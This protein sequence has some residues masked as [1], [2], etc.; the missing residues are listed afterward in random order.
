MKRAVS[1]KG[2][3]LRDK[4]AQIVAD[5]CGN[6]AEWNGEDLTVTQIIAV[7]AAWNALFGELIREAVKKD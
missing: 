7:D 6:P 2:P 4:L 3:E 5:A 1:M